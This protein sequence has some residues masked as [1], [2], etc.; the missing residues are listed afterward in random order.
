MSTTDRV[1][2]VRD[3]GHEVDVTNMRVEHRPPV[4]K[5]VACWSACDSVPMV[6]RPRRPLLVVRYETRKG[7]A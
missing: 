1:I 6:S 2:L 5:E 7:A 3:C 4:G